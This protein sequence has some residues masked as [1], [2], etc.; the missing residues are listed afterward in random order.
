MQKEKP[1][2]DV[3]DNVTIGPYEDA[4]DEV[5]YVTV[6]RDIAGH[7]EDDIDHIQVHIDGEEHSEE[8]DCERIAFDGWGDPLKQ[9]WIDRFERSNYI[10]YMEVRKTP[11]GD[12]RVDGV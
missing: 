11:S 7:G 8:I 4:G 5:Y 6:V 1:N 12:I 3:G 10:L 2:V 9:K